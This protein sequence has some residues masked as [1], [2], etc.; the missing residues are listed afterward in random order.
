MFPVGEGGGVGVGEGG[1][2]GEGE[3]SGAASTVKVASLL[4]TVSYK[5]KTLQ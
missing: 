3:G 1:G 4:V 2:V 5:F